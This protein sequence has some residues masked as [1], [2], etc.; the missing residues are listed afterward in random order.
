[1]T[2]DSVELSLR[3]VVDYVAGR[4]DRQ[5]FEQAVHPDWLLMLRQHLSSGAG[6]SA[7]SINRYPNTDDDGLVIQFAGYDTSAAPFRPISDVED[8]DRPKNDD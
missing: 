1:M 5:T 4:I 8:T 2:V 3:A 6:V 7:V